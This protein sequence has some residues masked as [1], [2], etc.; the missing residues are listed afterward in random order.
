MP[1]PN[2]L[3]SL[4][5]NYLKTRALFS[6]IIV[7]IAL[8]LAHSPALAQGS[9]PPTQEPLILTDEQGQYP[10]GLHLD[11]LEDP[12][13]ELTIEDVSSPEYAARFEPSQEAVPN[14]G[15]TES[16][17]WLRLRVRNETLST[18]Q[19]LLESAF[20]NLNYLDLYLP[21]D[22]GGFKVKETGILRPFNTRDIPYYHVVFELPLASQAEQTFFIRVES[23]S[24]MTL[25]FTLW[26]PETFAVNKIYDMLFVGLFYGALLLALGY[27]LVLYF[28]LREANYLY[29]VLF[30]ASSIIF[31]A[32]YE[33]IADQFLWPGLSEE[34][35]PFLAIT[36]AMFFIA[37]LKFSDVFLEQS[38]RAPLFHRLFYIF[39]GVWVMLIVIEPFS[40]YGLMAQLVTVLLLLTPLLAAV[41]GIYSWR[42]GYQPARFYLISW[43][44]FLLGVIIL[45]LVRT[46][47]LP[48]TP[49][50]E[51]A[52]HAGLIWLVLMWS[53]ALADRINRL[54]AQTEDT[55]RL[56]RNSQSRLSQILEGLPLGVVVYGKDAKPNYVNQRAVQILSNPSRG[57]W[58]GI[59]GG[60]TLAQSI[61]YFSFRVAGSDQK[62]PIENMPVS[63]AFQGESAWTD[64]VE[65]D[66]VDKRV[67]L[68]IWASPIKDDH[69]NVETAI[70]AFQDI[71]SRKNAEA[72]LDEYRHH[73]EELVE[74]RTTELS[75]IND[76][77]TQ[78]VTER[79]FLEGMLHKRI[80]WLS[81][82]NQ[83][84]QSVNSTADLPQAFQQLSATVIQLLE[85]KGALIG[86]FDEQPDQIDV[87]C[88][89]QPDGQPPLEKRFP[90]L[91]P[92][93]WALRQDLEAGKLL[94]LSPEQAGTLPAPL[95]ECF[96]AEALQSVILAP[97]KSHETLLGLLGLGISK[98]AQAFTQA[99]RDLVEKIAFDLADLAEDAHMFEKAQALAASEERN[100]LA[101][102]L[103]DSVTQVLFTASLVAEA[104]PQIWQRDPGMA[105]HSLNELRRLTRGALAEM[106]TMLLEL[107]PAAM[108]KAPLGELLAQLTEAVTSRSGLPFQ[109][110][111]EQVPALPE[112]VHTSFYRVA[113]EGL[114][115]VVKH[116]QASL[117][118]VS[119][120][121]TPASSAAGDVWKG[122]VKLSI[123][124]NGRG[125]SLQDKRSE[126][127][128]LSIIRERAASINAAVNIDSQPGD[129]TQLTLIWQN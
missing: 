62:Y 47:I 57:I 2:G 119:L 41:S 36:M 111:I 39:S 33:G 51:R 17:I 87:L 50:T 32:T 37:S 89:T 56:L 61:D 60:R 15:L 69:G 30:L 84:H 23:G 91:L 24:S 126:H 114:N 31:W 109:L 63:R 52:Y 74:Q 73:L 72:E 82:I 105:Q 85:A 26:E 96:Q 76:Q 6:I 113:Q 54:K 77:L 70:A 40:S 115:N 86:V 1:L 121:A 21:L 78:E 124:D 10:L 48:S 128:G 53:I 68:E 79:K 90:I 46:D 117:V 66:L 4:R 11:I 65:A 28:S 12:G 75:L 3:I 129:G 20:P 64:D 7:L 93:D 106:R 83:I 42:K 71:T 34:K 27:H 5:V 99:E 13:G 58:A 59:A 16:V 118:T 123:K 67:P 95:K 107:R 104:L 100:R 25:A 19:W 22:E 49:I 44:G 127:M 29:F 112:E 97:M 108:T 102:D 55:N 88:S 92:K 120:S 125:F 94:I 18:N 81:T 8:I 38:T 14:Y 122:E 101:R 35:Q 116:A 43:I 45:D 98:P 80:E 110:F 9:A 103:H